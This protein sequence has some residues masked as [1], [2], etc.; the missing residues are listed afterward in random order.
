MD[1]QDQFTKED[2]V[3]MLEQH[4]DE[5]RNQE[6][7]NHQIPYRAPLCPMHNKQIEAE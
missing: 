3:E 2:F 5:I 1:N 7:H 4:Q 6:G